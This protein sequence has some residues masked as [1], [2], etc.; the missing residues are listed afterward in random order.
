MILDY[1]LFIDF[2]FPPSLDELLIR[3]CQKLNNQE[4]IL[5]DR[6]VAL[7]DY[8]NKYVKAAIHLNKFNG[9]RHSRNLLA[10][11]LH[12]YLNSHVKQTSLLLPVPLSRKR[13]RDRGYN[14]VEEVARIA[15]RDL[16]NVILVKDLL[17]KE[18]HTKPQ[19]TLGKTDR[20]N[21]VKGTFAAGS[22][23]KYNSLLK[24]YPIILLDDVT[25]TGATLAAARAEL[26]TLSPVSVICVALAH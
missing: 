25:T 8:K 5:A 19:T 1:K 26:S 17:V 18:K 4:S 2:I 12:E 16:E 14:Q 7:C 9:H 6:T 13:Q 10:G 20:L 21:N 3:R 23:A 15:C 24:K 11:A 22:V